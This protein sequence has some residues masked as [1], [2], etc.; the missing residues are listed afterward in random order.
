M[1]FYRDLPVDKQIIHSIESVVIDWC[2]Q[3]RD[4]LQK[5]SAQALLEGKNPGPLVEVEFWVDRCADLQFI[6]EQ[7]GDFCS[8]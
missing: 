1:L 3:V 2:H 8:F 4:V 6:L 5:N 7:V